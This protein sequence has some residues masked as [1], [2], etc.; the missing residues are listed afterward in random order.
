[1]DSKRE[2]SEEVKVVKIFQKRF[3]V[4]RN[5]RNANKS[6]FDV[7]LYPNHIQ[8]IINT[9]GG[10]CRKKGI[11]IQCWWHCKLVQKLWKAMQKTPRKAKRKSALRP[12]YTTPLYMSKI[13]VILIY[14]Y[15]LCCVHCFSIQNSQDWKK[16]NVFNKNVDN[17]NVVHIHSE[18]L[19]SFKEK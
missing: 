10:W 8:Q 2:L 16:L 3:I 12:S 13:L 1:M 9:E 19:F 15:L 18:I 14:R 6:I 7:S 4:L 11:L 5:Q 17:K